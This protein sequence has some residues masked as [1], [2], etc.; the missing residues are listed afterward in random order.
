[1]TDW[2][3][4]LSVSTSTNLQTM[5]AADAGVYSQ[6]YAKSTDR[7][8]YNGMRDPMNA[9]MWKHHPLNAY[10]Q[11]EAFGPSN[12]IFV[13]GTQVLI[14]TSVTGLVLYMPMKR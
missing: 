3:H 12:P 14:G 8:N 13:T 2:L 1:M 11:I 10:F 7:V 9:W 6:E 5:Y 4:N